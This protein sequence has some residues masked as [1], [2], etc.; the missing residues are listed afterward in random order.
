MSEI[1][2]GE[3]VRTYDGYIGK[4]VKNIPNVLNNLKIDV[5]REIKHCDNSIDNYIYTR[6]GFIVKYSEQLV[7]LIEEGDYVNGK[8]IH[9]VLENPKNGETMICYGNGKH[10]DNKHIKSIV[11]K[12]IFEE[13]EY[14]L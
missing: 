14:K 13:M 10:I 11:T 3:Y 2:V 9:Y 7:D 5:K 1:K 8:L 6:K 12:E 4:L